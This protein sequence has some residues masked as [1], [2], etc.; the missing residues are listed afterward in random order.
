MCNTLNGKT[1]MKLKLYGKNGVMGTKDI[2]NITICKLKIN[3]HKTFVEVC[4]R[5]TLEVLAEICQADWTT[6][7][8]AKEKTENTLKKEVIFNC[9][10]FYTSLYTYMYSA[11]TASISYLNHKEMTKSFA[12]SFPIMSYFW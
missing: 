2:Q 11:M 9:F 12:M 6:E 10:V 1:T 5:M 7:C 8:T 4:I 3:K